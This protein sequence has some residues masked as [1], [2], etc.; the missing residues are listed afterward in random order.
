MEQE[1]IKLNEQR[2]RNLGRSKSTLQALAIIADRGSTSGYELR[3]LGID[4]ARTLRT[5]A[6]AGLVR[7]AHHGKETK[8]MLVKT[9]TE[10]CIEVPLG[11]LTGRYTANQVAFWMMLER[12]RRTHK[13]PLRMNADEFRRRVGSS[14][15][16]YKIS[17]GSADKRGNGHMNA[18]CDL[19]EADGW[20]KRARGTRMKKGGQ[21]EVGA[22]EATRP[23][24]KR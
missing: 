12:H 1:T 9:R 24:E 7:G 2:I 11:L 10:I 18:L 23:W 21:Y 6:V 19:L 3:L 17:G 5:L 4:G 20:V 22:F 15:R 8:Y 14:P 16:G 13:A